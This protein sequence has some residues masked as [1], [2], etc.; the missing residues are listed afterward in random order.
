MAESIAIPSPAGQIPAFS[1]SPKG[2][3]RGAVIV[4][5]EAFGLTEHIAEI[6]D[7]LAA[8]GY[9]SIAPALFHRQGSPVV[10]Y[11]ALLVAEKTERLLEIM[12]QL[13]GEEIAADLDATLEHLVAEG[14]SAE[15]TGMVGFCMGG[16]VVC[17]A[18]SRPGIAAGVTFYGGGVTTGRFG[19]PPLVE[20][21]PAIVHPWLGLYGDEDPSIPVE[22]VEALRDAA[23]TATAP[24]EIIRYA[25]AGHGFNCDARPDHFNAAAAAD[26]WSRM[27]AFFAEHLD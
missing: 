23:A 15:S 14:F 4:V 2:R 1:S 6:V 27:L 8:E 22:Q 10:E 20:V 17:A 26:G 13:S 19:M 25:A 11:E 24:T 12:G 16:A 21:A 3:A 7:R 18:C 9:R 5:Q